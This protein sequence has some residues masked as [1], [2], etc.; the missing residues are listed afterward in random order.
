MEWTA[1]GLID[2]LPELG[3]LKENRKRKHNFIPQLSKIAR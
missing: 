1:H 2:S 3:L